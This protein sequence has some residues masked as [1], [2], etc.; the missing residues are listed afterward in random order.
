[1]VSEKVDKIGEELEENVR[2]EEEEKGC[3]KEGIF[4]GWVG[5]VERGEE[6][7]EVEELKEKGE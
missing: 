4:Y 3:G 1:M 5:Y 6:R 2:E 7:K